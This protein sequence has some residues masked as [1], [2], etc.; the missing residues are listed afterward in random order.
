M[1][2]EAASRVTMSDGPGDTEGLK[3][4]MRN[5][6]GGRSPVACMSFASS[7]AAIESGAY[8]NVPATG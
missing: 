5:L 7:P 4:A 1:L 3:E 8:Y 6:V 2:G